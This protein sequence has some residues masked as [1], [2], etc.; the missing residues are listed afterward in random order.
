[1][2]ISGSRP[3]W[4]RSISAH[5]LLYGQ[6]PVPAPG[7][8]MKLLEYPFYYLFILLVIFDLAVLAY[9]VIKSRDH[10]SW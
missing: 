7:D 9:I 10:D 6:A 8:T 1:M 2:L 5:D 4:P 3:T